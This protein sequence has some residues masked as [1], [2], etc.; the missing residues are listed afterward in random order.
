MTQPQI[1]RWPSYVAGA[2]RF[3]MPMVTVLVDHQ[4]MVNFSICCGGAY[5]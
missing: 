5:G 4:S 2:K 1:F 3:A